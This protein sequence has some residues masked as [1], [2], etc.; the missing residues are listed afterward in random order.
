MHAR[1]YLL[2]TPYNSIHVQYHHSFLCL[3]QTIKQYEL[4]LQMSLCLAEAKKDEERSLIK[5]NDVSP[6]QGGPVI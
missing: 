6:L 4:F 5:S 3:F 1:R 2:P